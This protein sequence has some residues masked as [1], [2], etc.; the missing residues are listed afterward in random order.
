ME[1]VGTSSI[2]GI[3]KSRKC[4]S[5]ELENYMKTHKQV[6]WTLKKCSEG[7]LLC[8]VGSDQTCICD[9]SRGRR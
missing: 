5:H 4:V 2:S 9:T 3:L 8:R 1:S 6:G 7:H